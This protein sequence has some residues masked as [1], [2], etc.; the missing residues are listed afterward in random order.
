M[1]IEIIMARG[2][3]GHSSSHVRLSPGDLNAIWHL[4][5]A[6]GRFF[7]HMSPAAQCTTIGVPSV[8]GVFWMAK[9]D[10]L[11]EKKKI[12]NKSRKK[13]NK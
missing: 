13:L 12:K 8:A 7:W 9:W 10:P 2:S 4:T 11:V 5:Q 1:I 3:F 6:I